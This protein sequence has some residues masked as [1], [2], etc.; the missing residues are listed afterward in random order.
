MV[1]VKNCT[2]YIDSK[3]ATLED[4][5]EI[6]DAISRLLAE[7]YKLIEIDLSMAQ[8]LP[9]ELIGLLMWEKKT[10]DKEGKRMV[11]SKINST[12]AKIFEN[13]LLSDF[14]EIDESSIQ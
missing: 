12:L 4:K 7:G 3:R 9:S 10:M 13:A 5:V 6:E 1:I 2:I 14:F 8:Y 11:I